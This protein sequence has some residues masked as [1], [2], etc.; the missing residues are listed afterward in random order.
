MDT[1]NA[2]S[3][4]LPSEYPDEFEELKPLLSPRLVLGG[5]YLLDILFGTDYAQD[6]DLFASCIAVDPLIATLRAMGYRE[7][8]VAPSPF[9]D[10]GRIIAH[11]PG[12]RNL[13]IC[14]SDLPIRDMI[15]RC[16]LSANRIFFDGNI[17]VYTS[18]WNKDPRLTTVRYAKHEIGPLFDSAVK[19]PDNFILNEWVPTPVYRT[20]W[21]MFKYRS[22]GYEF[23]DIYGQKF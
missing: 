6:I 10:S 1:M 19:D 7:M 23:Y 15:E 22:R 21:N 2:L 16:D 14:T 8:T 18:E 9:L 13:D 5:S 20:A 17:L 12:R 11:K 4:A 3:D